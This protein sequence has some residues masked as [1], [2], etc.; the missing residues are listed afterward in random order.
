MRAGGPAVFI[1]GNGEQLVLRVVARHADVW[2]VAVGEVATLRNKVAVLHERCAAVGRDPGCI[3]LSAQ[4]RIDLADPDPGR[5][6]PS[7]RPAPT[8][9]SSSSSAPPARDGDLA[10]RRDRRPPALNARWG[11]QPAPPGVV[12][13][14]RCGGSGCSPRSPVGQASPGSPPG[15]TPQTRPPP[16]RTDPGRGCGSG[17]YWRAAGPIGDSGPRTQVMRVDEATSRR[18]LR[19][20]TCRLESRVIS[21]SDCRRRPHRHTCPPE[22]GMLNNNCRS[23]F[24]SRPKS[25]RRPSRTRTL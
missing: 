11:E 12:P 15:R 10:G 19:V 3:G 13:R 2:N 8:T 20:A 6:R 9:S 7:S 1:G 17:G 21:N 22:P 14:Q 4:V 18:G 24:F 5:R 23:E 16:P 25:S